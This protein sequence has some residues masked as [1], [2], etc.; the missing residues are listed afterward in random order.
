MRSFRYNAV[1]AFLLWVVFSACSHPR[2]VYRPT[3]EFFAAGKF[4]VPLE[5]QRG[6]A[7]RSDVEA[8]ARSLLGP[9]ALEAAR[10]DIDHDG[11]AELFVQAQAHRATG[12]NSFLVFAESRAGFRYLGRL[13][14]GILRP[15]PADERGR[16]R[17]LTSSWAGGGECLVQ[18]W[19][20][21]SDGF[22]SITNR[23]LPCGDSAADGVGGRLHKLLFDSDAPMDSLRDV[24]P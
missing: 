6:E 15:L 12:G 18:I 9:H 16:P 4:P 2:R 19:Q 21:N 17:V 24:F 20:L 1:V 23:F 5:F 8:W 10:V 7:T 11:A 13:N 14:F 3:D 22:H